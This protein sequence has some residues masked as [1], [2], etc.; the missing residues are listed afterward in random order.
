M[1]SWISTFSDTA[2]RS[3]DEMAASECGGDDLRGVGPQGRHREGPRSPWKF[4]ELGDDR[5]EIDLLTASGALI[6]N[7]AAARMIAHVLGTSPASV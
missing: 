7:A 4:S 1:Q 5:A 2:A 3:L 6:D